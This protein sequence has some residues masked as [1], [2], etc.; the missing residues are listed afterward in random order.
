MKNDFPYD[1]IA[2]YHT[3]LCPLRHV[4][5][6]HHLYPEEIK[7]LEEIMDTLE[8]EKYFDS[9]IINFTK[10]RTILDHYHIHLIKYSHE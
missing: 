3:I 8:K 7:E 6:K 1:R 9:I 2:A 4:P 10:N 5:D